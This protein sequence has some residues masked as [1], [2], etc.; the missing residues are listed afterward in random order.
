MVG[1]TTSD[2]SGRYTSANDAFQR[3]V[4][5]TE[6]EICALRPLDLT[7]EDDRPLTRELIDE[8]MSG[9]RQDYQLEKRYRRKD[10]EVIWVNVYCS[11]VPGSDRVPDFYQAIIV[12]ITERKRAETALRSSEER[13]RRLFETSSAGM[14]LGTIDGKFLVTNRA[15]QNMLGYTEQEL[16]ARAGVDLTLPEDIPTTRRVLAEFAKGAAQEYHIEKRYIRK[17]GSVI[18]VNISAT[19]VPAS[20]S[21]P[22]LLQG[23]FI[24]VTKR[25]RAET[26]LRASEARWRAVFETTSVGIATSD[27]DRRLT[28]SNSAFQHMLGYGEAELLGMDAL[29]FT[30]EDDIVPTQRIA[31]EVTSGQRPAY[32]IEKRY[33]R[34][35]GGVIWVSVSASRIAATETMRGLA[36]VVD[37]TDRKRAEDALRRAQAELGRVARLTT[38]GELGASIAHE[39]NQPL[40]A[41]VASGNACRRWIANR[42]D[43]GRASESVDRIISDAHRASEV[44][45]RIRALTSKKAPER[46][47]L[48]MSNVIEE[49]LEFTRSELE[50]K[51][52]SV[53][54]E[55][56]DRSAILGD[57]VQLQQVLLNLV[58]NAIEAMTPIVDRRRELAITSQLGA[59]GDVVVTVQDSGTGLN[60]D[61]A[62]RIFDPFFTTKADG[63][64]MGLSI[65]TSIIDA[66]GGRLWCSPAAPRG[67][68]FY[69]TVPAG[70]PD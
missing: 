1:I 63:M 34:K 53:R 12:D 18:W 59:Q 42:R 13:W 14:A 66:H 37:I 3:M 45:K 2:G 32:Q 25:K 33:R 43:L 24:D 31:A 16:R 35:D 65:S 20:E 52:I 36:M 47:R 46:M 17:D 22:R 4:G 58:M 9:G 69:F 57:R 48:D 54:K 62:D 67:T 11:H 30:H 15:F 70:G 55:L 64:G 61:D 44:I 23:I 38:V 8:L 10:R 28:W 41:I 29:A 26:A 19:A 7:H 68:A 5:Y 21:A 60:P 39:I 40:A 49:V 51:Q 56:A 50:A 27:A 6:K